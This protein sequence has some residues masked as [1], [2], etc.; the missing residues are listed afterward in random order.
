[1]EETSELTFEQA[2]QQLDGIVQQL[3]STALPLEQSLLL[4][5]RGMRLARLCEAKLDQAEQKVTQLVG[6]TQEG[7][8]LMPLGIED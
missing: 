5:E 2:F 1:M 4:F 3:E 7:P 8:T 6:T